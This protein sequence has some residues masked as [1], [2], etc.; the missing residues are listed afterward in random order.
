MRASPSP[1]SSAPWSAGYLEENVAAAELVFTAAEAAELD[2]AV[3]PGATAGPR[4]TPQQMAMVD[5]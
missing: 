2:A 1:R 5:R 4:Y 3:P